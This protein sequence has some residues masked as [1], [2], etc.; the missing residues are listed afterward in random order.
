MRYFLLLMGAMLLVALAALVPFAIAMLR[1]RSA[2]ARREAA[3]A[4]HRAQ[5]D[6]IARDLADQRIDAESYQGARLEIERRLLAADALNEATAS[7]NARPLLIAVAVL[8]PVMAFVLYLPGSTPGVPSEPHASW[9]VQQHK[10]QQELATLIAELRARLA[11]L[12]P[13]S[14]QASEGQAYLAEA[15]AEQAGRLTPEAI[16]LFK[17]SYSHAPNAAAWRSLDAERLT[18]AGVAPGSGS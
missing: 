9:V 14:T 3:I 15:L 13:N 16:S 17:L 6:E 11:G 18:E 2:R 8:V 12:D 10:E 5:L 4:L 7:G 1:R